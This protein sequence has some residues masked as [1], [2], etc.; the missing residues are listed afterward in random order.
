MRSPAQAAPLP[1][2]GDDDK[3]PRKPPKDEPIQPDIRARLST[4]LPNNAAALKTDLEKMLRDIRIPAPE[5]GAPITP[6]QSPLVLV[7]C[8]QGNQR[9][10]VWR[11]PVDDKS[12]K[13][14]IA[15][16]DLLPKDGLA[17]DIGGGFL[18]RLAD[19]AAMVLP[20]MTRVQGNDV[21][22][23]GLQV[24]LEPPS[25]VVTVISGRIVRPFR[26]IRFKHRLIATLIVNEKSLIACTARAET[27]PD[28]GDLAADLLASIFLSGGLGTNIIA[29]LSNAF[30]R[31][32]S[33]GNN[34]TPEGGLG[35][36]LTQ[37]ARKSVFLEGPPS[38][39]IDFTYTQAQVT[40]GSVRFTALLG[41]RNARP[42][43][44]IE[45]AES[46]A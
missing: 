41:P 17:I 28:G 34:D 9:I 30:R 33:I 12:Q 25:N 44:F 18:N 29:M 14:G 36:Y 32:A 43:V 3:P 13:A 6:F 21:L 11:E 16:V 40:A 4:C 2:P 26:N 31:T 42:Q 20:R 38:L 1:I 45:P 46:S 37:F 7:S 39:A 23:D 5:G 24:S 35:C 27:N 19:L 10:A 8:V 22:L 15:A